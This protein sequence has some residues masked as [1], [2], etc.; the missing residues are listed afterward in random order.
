MISL[1]KEVR[2][3]D[4]AWLERTPD[5]LRVEAELTDFAATAALISICDLVISVDTSVAH[6]AGALGRP[7]WLLLPKPCD[8]RW[9][10]NRDDTPWYPG[11]RLVRQ[12]EPGDWAEVLE[13]AAQALAGWRP[14]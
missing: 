12:A 4:V 13:R 11:A 9:M 1:Q 5:V 2:A 7:L 8:W 3:V 10:S 6:L 14:A